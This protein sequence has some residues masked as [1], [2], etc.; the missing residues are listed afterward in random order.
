M[1]LLILDEPVLNLQQLYRADL[2]ALH[3]AHQEDIN[4]AF[5]HASYRQF[6][7]WQ[8]GRLGEGDRRVVPSCCV[9]RIRDKFPDTSGTYTGFTAGR[10]N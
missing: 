8:F 2:F 5:R 9:W 1:D 10:L 6:T 4:R 3:A 7:L